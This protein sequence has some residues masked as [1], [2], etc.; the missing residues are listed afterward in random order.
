M[1]RELLGL[2]GACSLAFLTYIYSINIKDLMCFLTMKMVYIF[3]IY[4]PIDTK[5]MSQKIKK[6]KILLKV[7]LN[8]RNVLHL[9][10]HIVVVQQLA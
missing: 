3:G 8:N 4:L 5:L 7:F 1:G 6:I 2:Q 10:L 9:I